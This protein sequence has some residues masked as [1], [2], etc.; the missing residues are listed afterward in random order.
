MRRDT[1]YIHVRKTSLTHPDYLNTCIPGRHRH[2]HVCMR[3]KSG[4]KM[5]G[6][7]R[8]GSITL[9]KESE[10]GLLRVCSAHAHGLQ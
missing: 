10:M 6:D 1:E 3:G 7:K 5:G 2:S 4:E 8:Y 9:G